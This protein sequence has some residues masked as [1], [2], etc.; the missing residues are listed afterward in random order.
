MIIYCT[1][2]RVKSTALKDDVQKVWQKGTV[3]KKIILKK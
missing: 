1:E 3:L 2:R